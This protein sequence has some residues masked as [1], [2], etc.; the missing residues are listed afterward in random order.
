VFSG[1]KYRQCTKKSLKL[2]TSFDVGVGERGIQVLHPESRELLID[3][4]F[5]NL[6]DWNYSRENETL[7]FTISP[8]M[9]K[10][11]MT[12]FELTMHHSWALPEILGLM[13]AYAQVLLERSTVA[14]VIEPHKSA[15]PDMLSID[16]GEIV[17]VT[18]KSTSGWFRGECNGRSGF[19][20][21]N[22]V[23]M[24]FAS[25]VE[26]QDLYSKRIAVLKYQSASLV[27]HRSVV[28]ASM[29]SANTAGLHAYKQQYFTDPNAEFCFS[30]TPISQ[31]L[32]Q[33]DQMTTTVYA[34]DMFVRVMKWM[35]DY[36]VGKSSLYSIMTDMLQKV[37]SG[38]APGLVDELYCQI[39][40]QLTQNTNASSVERGFMLLAI[41]SG[42]IKPTNTQLHEI[43]VVYLESVAHLSTLAKSILR[44]LTS[45][46]RG[47]REYAPGLKE[48]IAASLGQPIPL[49]ITLPGAQT[50]IH[51]SS[52]TTVKEAV[53]IVMRQLNIRSTDGFGLWIDS[54]ISDEEFVCDILAQWGRMAAN[55]ALFDRADLLELQFDE[56]DAYQPVILCNKIFFDDVLREAD[57]RDDPKL[58]QFLVSQMLW[59]IKEVSILLNDD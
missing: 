15:T 33:F 45:R 52:Q 44:N 10:M 21:A 25:P 49:T 54:P 8:T 47:R 51:V 26:G 11:S 28:S 12:L 31:S 36:P 18:Q 13:N 41:L 39:W 48:L 58:M 6:V 24:L 55:K 19:F 22:S 1:C 2:T 46:M 40:H 53:D 43:L 7:C 42:I 3:A 17:R 50:V 16:V 29:A 9:T 14:I 35:G 32:H 34:T 4:P 20:A 5:A 23:A 56:L 30:T 59:Q 38:N 37:I 27:S 57:L